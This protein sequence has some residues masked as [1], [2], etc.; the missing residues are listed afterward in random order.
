MSDWICGACTHDEHGNHDD[1]GCKLTASPGSGQ[2]CACAWGEEDGAD[3]VAVPVDELPAL[4]TAGGYYPLPWYVADMTRVLLITE[5]HE[6]ALVRDIRKIAVQALGAL[7][8][9]GVL[10]DA[11]DE[12]EA[13]ALEEEQPTEPPRSKRKTSAAVE[14]MQTEGITATEIREWAAREGR[15]VSDRGALSMEV[16]QA[17]IAAHEEGAA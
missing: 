14:L 16:V 2:R 1:D 3:C 9:M 17:Y 4:I 5:L 15:H 13:T 10:E 7:N 11:I 8:R 12:P 6:D